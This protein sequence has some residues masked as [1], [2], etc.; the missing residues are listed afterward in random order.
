MKRPLISQSAAAGMRGGCELFDTRLF[1]TDIV[2][3]SGEA[4]DEAADTHAG[5]GYPLPIRRKD[6]MEQRTGGEKG[7]A[8]GGF[9]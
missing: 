8:E 2:V 4:Y 1:A 6:G 7:A 5:G 9:P 3:A